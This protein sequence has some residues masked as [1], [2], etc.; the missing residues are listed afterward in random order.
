MTADAASIPLWH[1]PEG[2]GAN[3]AYEL[4]LAMERRVQKVKSVFLDV[5]FWIDCRDAVAD[6]TAASDKRALYAMLVR[7]VR[8]ERLACPISSDILTE[9]T[10]Q[11]DAS[12]DATMVVV[13]ELTRGLSLVNHQERAVIE[14]ERLL[15]GFSPAL[16]A[17]HRPIWTAFVF[18]FGYQD[19]APPRTITPNAELLKRMTELAWR[20]PPSKGVAAL[21]LSITGA[22]EESERSATRL[23]QGA[24]AYRHEAP[25]FAT[26][27]R[28]ELA[29]AADL[30][31][32]TLASEYDRMAALA[33]APAGDEQLRMTLIQMAALGMANPEGRRAFGNM[34]VPA[35]LHAAIRAEPGRRFKPNDIYDIR[36]ATA[37]LPNCD[38]FFTEG[39][40]ARLMASGH[41]GLAHSYPCAIASTRDEAIDVL[42]GFGIN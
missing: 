32:A 33:G 2:P 16:A 37:A 6:P 20:L 15:G 8:E 29:G 12:L 14:V 17:P 31:S 25:D 30:L 7:G 23:N 40:L 41:V 1:W 3:C 36:H 39:K 38:A 34:V 19:L 27:L 5:N 24:E 28:H 26:V 21:R 22:K 11:D 10:K 9:L 18:A 35:T 13:D 4:Q 42:Q